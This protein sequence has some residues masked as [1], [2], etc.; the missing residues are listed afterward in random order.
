MNSLRLKE[1]IRRDDFI[2]RTGLQPAQIAPTID[3]ACQ[4]GLMEAGEWFRATDKGQQYLNELLALFLPE[5]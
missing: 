5:E 3:K 1:G 2:A 4:A